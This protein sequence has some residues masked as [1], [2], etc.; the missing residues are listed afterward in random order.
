M[1]E[2]QVHFDV[3]SSQFHYIYITQVI[4]EWRKQ[5]QQQ[6]NVNKENDDE[7]KR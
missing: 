1:N 3:N 6:P 5:Q 4:R 2:I 7:R